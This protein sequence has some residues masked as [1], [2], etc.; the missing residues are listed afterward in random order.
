MSKGS[1][2]IKSYRV[3]E[4]WLLLSALALLVSPFIRIGGPV[5]VT[6][7]EFL[8][9]PVE[10]SDALPAIAFFYLS[11]LALVFYVFV[12]WCRLEKSERKRL[13]C[14]TLCLFESIAVVILYWRYADLF[15]DS[16]YG[17]FSPIWF[18]PFIALGYF[19]GMAGAMFRF[20]FSLR[21]SR[22]EAKRKNLPLMPRQAKGMIFGSVLLVLLVL[23]PCTVAAF[24]FYPGPTWWVPC[25]FFIVSIVPGLSVYVFLYEKPP[26]G[27]LPLDKLKAITD[28][29]DHMEHIVPL[30]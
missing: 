26:D 18:V 15:K 3:K 22:D 13:R 11:T 28:W 25:V 9:I 16:P 1:D 8:E 10:V 20:A 23:V 19:F 21:R 29:S 14:W 4:G 5:T 27:I 12:E 2:S 7:K 30:P 24:Y 17:R 6:I